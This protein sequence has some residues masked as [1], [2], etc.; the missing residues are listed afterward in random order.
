LFWRRKLFVFFFQLVDELSKELEELRSLK[1]ELLSKSPLGR[2][3]E[4]SKSHRR[5]LEEQLSR[6]KAVSKASFDDFQFVS[7]RVN[8][9]CLFH[10][11]WCS[12]DVLCLAFFFTSPQLITYLLDFLYYFTSVSPVTLSK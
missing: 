12:P 7:T 10:L 5:L 8:L 11:S 4:M 1:A 2:D 6:L 9:F 3:A